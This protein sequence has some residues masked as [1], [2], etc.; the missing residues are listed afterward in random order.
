MKLEEIESVKHIDIES[1]V[2]LH[3]KLILDGACCLRFGQYFYREL[4]DSSAEIIATQC[5]MADVQ[6]YDIQLP[7]IISIKLDSDGIITDAEL[8]RTFK[9]SQ[10]IP[11]A[12]KFLARNLREK[13]VGKKLAPNADFL[14][15]QF[16]L[17][18]RHV[19]ELMFGA[20]ML[21]REAR[22][23]QRSEYRIRELTQAVLKDDKLVVDDSILVNGTI[24]RNRVIFNSFA[25]HITYD[26]DGFVVK[27]EDI[28]A[29][30]FKW[31][32]SSESFECYD[33]EL[34]T[35]RTHK[36]FIMS[37]MKLLSVPWMAQKNNVG[38]RNKFYCSQLWP[39]TLIGIVVQAFGITTFH[40]NYEY[41]MQCIA[42]LQRDESG[43]PLC[44]G[45]IR[46]LEEAKKHFPGL[47]RSDL[48]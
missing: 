47:D 48:W 31:D 37:L 32:E 10:G 13:T 18:C 29:S 21:Y 1:I 20:C 6:N 16:A 27:L 9:G 39:P 25:N 8:D 4:E 30:F 33:K 15:D 42:G 2:E 12:Y 23:Q 45:I 36:E 35:A 40:N 5:N 24:D 7:T 19:F 11:C 22:Q 3:R 43:K 14:T 38:F 28:K 41:F 26:K 34:L 17:C 46:N 44:V